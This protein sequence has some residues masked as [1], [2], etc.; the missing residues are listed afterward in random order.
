[1]RGA[2]DHGGTTIGISWGSACWLERDVV[3]DGFKLGDQRA[4]FSFGA[5]P[6]GR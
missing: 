6:P 4:G 1:M 2:A 3:P 5:S